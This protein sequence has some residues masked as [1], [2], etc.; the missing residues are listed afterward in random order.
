MEYT[1]G[2]WLLDD[3]R[4]GN[5]SLAFAKMKN[6]IPEFKLDN[7]TTAVKNNL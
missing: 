6:V 5:M 3:I 2:K 1:E 4:E 7:G